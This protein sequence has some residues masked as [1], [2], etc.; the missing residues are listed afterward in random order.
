MRNL[1]LGQELELIC[2]SK[3]ESG[4]LVDAGRH[5][6]NAKKTQPDHWLSFSSAKRATTMRAYD[7]EY[8]G[9][10]KF[11]ERGRK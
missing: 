10:G 6:L 2:V 9:T 7:I 4:L 11:P 3:S 8:F 5:H 1:V